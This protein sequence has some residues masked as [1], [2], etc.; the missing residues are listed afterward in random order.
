MLVHAT[1]KEINQ[2]TS[3]ERS[4]EDR[5]RDRKHAKN[6]LTKRAKRGQ[7]NMLNTRRGKKICYQTKGGVLGGQM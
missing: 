5:K 7:T 4:K 2:Q 6:I 3:K 1:N